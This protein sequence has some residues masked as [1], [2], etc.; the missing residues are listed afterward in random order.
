LRE[1]TIKK[2]QKLGSRDSLIEQ[3]KEMNSNQLE[4]ISKYLNVKND[5]VDYNDE[6]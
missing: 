3:I 1:L 5:G 2:L 6:A 4:K